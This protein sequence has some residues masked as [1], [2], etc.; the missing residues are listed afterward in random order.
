MHTGNF[1]RFLL[2]GRSQTPDPV[3]VIKSGMRIAC[4]A[5]AVGGGPRSSQQAGG[6]LGC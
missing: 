3:L 4:A 2:I 5:A 6:M 1:D